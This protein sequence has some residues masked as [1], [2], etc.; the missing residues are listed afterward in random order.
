MLQISE[1]CFG[2]FHKDWL[3]RMTYE[4]Y[5][6]KLL[7]SKTED[8]TSLYIDRQGYQ[9]LGFFLISLLPV[10]MTLTPYSS[11]S[12]LSARVDSG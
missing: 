9:S 7:R 12:N 6:E 4:E 8:N 2:S 1:D 10:A 11:Y 3:Y 5:F